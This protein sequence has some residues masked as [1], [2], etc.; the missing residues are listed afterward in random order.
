MKVE[1]ARIIVI[2]DQQILNCESKTGWD[3]D[4]VASLNELSSCVQATFQHIIKSNIY[5]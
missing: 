2:H 4:V 1:F 5:A 3:R